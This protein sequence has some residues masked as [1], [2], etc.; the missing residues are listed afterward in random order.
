MI[1]KVWYVTKLFDYWPKIRHSRKWNRRWT[2]RKFEICY[3]KLFRSFLRAIVMSDVL[4]FICGSFFTGEIYKNRFSSNSWWYHLLGHFWPNV[5][6]IPRLTL[7]WRLEK[8][9]ERIKLESD[10]CSWKVLN[11]VGKVL[12]PANVSKLVIGNCFDFPAWNLLTKV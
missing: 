8:K 11:E 4:L 2:H 1:M 9:L 5:T 10:H 12:T 3:G 6:V 7:A